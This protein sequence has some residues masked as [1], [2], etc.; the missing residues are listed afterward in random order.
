MAATREERI[1]NRLF[2]GVETFARKGFT[3]LPIILRRAQFLFSPREW[4]VYTYVLM[5]T[6]K[7]GVA[8]LTMTEMANDLAFNSTAKLR[9]YVDQL[10]DAGWLIAHRSSARE[11]FIAPDPYAV[12]KAL[13]KRDMISTE[14]RE[15]LDELLDLLGQDPLKAIAA[16]VESAKAGPPEMI[17][18]NG[19]LYV[20][21]NPVGPGE[22]HASRV[23]GAITQ[24]DFDRLVKEGGF[25]SLDASDK[26][27]TAPSGPAAK[28]AGRSSGRRP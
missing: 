18:H 3:T 26:G 20:R 9:K 15:E 25:T 21:A 1:R 23:P 8:W 5:R 12:L 27:S 11:Y 7:A 13:D 14:R 4:Q 10:V 28:K 24:E 2:P 6:G 19:K 22:D 17:S 16:P